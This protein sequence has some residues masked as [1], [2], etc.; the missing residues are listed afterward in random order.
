MRVFLASSKLDADETRRVMHKCQL[1]MMSGQ[2]EDLMYKSFEKAAGSA[3]DK[4]NKRK[5]KEARKET[6]LGDQAKKESVT[7]L[8]TS[9][10]QQFAGAKNKKKKFG[11][12]GA[13]G[14][15]SHQCCPQGR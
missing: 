9:L 7:E 15:S 8:V 5:E 4:K 2:T 3:V 10:L 13:S 1:D 6:G 12:K 14:E 11:K